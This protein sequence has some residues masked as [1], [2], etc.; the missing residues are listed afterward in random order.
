MH[1]KLSHQLQKLDQNPNQLSSIID[2]LSTAV[3]RQINKRSF[4]QFHLE[5]VVLS[6]LAECRLFSQ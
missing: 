6:K 3:N 2:L 1:K 5:F 4:N